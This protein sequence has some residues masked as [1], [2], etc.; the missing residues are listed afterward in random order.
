MSWE[1]NRF[2]MRNTIRVLYQKH[3]RQQTRCDGGG[4]RPPHCSGFLPLSSIPPRSE[5]SEVAKLVPKA[6]GFSAA[7]TLEREEEGGCH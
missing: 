3:L 7:G 2:L 4:V 1:R 5:L 6:T